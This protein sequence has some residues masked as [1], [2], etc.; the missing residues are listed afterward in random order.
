MKKASKIY[1]WAWAVF[2]VAAIVAVVVAMVMPS[3]HDLARDPYAIE[4][5]VKVDLPEIVE[6]ESED[7]LDRS[8]SRWDVYTHRV[9]F[10]DTLSEESIKELDRLCHNDS[11]HWRKNAE[12][13]YYHYTAEG[14]I[15]ELYAIDCVLYRDHAHWDYTV[16]ESEGIFLFVA[17]Y[18][19][20]YLM[21]LWGVVLVVI[22]IV[23]RI[24]K[25]KRQQQ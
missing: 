13:G 8:S 5:I 22:G 2:G 15:D 19:C 20:G 1:L 23:K 7:N 11:L 14:G 3:H 24:V 18:L 17:F 10:G 6:V 12:E 16:D 25:N 4:R 21:L 9:Q